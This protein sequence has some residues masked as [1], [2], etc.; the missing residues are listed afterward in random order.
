MRRL[1]TVSVAALALL[2]GATALG[3]D[4]EVSA[5]RLEA[6]VTLLADDALGGRE[7][8]TEGYN[9]AAGYVGGEFAA[10]GLDPAIGNHYFQTVP[11]RFFQADDPS[12]LSMTIIGRDGAQT[13]VPRDEIM[14]GTEAAVASASIEAPL[15]FVGSGFADDGLGWDDF[16]GV[17]VAGK[18]AVVLRNPP[19]IMG[20]QEYGYYRN[21]QAER[22]A[23]R[24]A[25]GM[26][27][28]VTPTYEKGIKFE[29]LKSDFEPAVN[30]AWLR[31]DGTPFAEVPD[32]FIRAFASEELGRRLMEGQPVSWEEAAAAE[33]DGKKRL[34][35]FELGF[36]ARLTAGN[37]LW[38]QNSYNVVGV[39]PGSDPAL[40]N[41][42][43][44]VTAHLDGVGTHVT[45]KKG[46]DE[47]VNAAMDNATGVAAI[48]EI[49][50]LLA[51]TPPRRTLV[52]AALTA[53]EKGL[54]GA[55]YLARN[56]V[57]AGTHKVVANINVD[58]PLSSWEFTDLVVYGVERT[59][60]EPVIRQSVASAGL[61]IVPDPQPEESYFTRSDHYRFVQQG[62]PS[63]YVNPGFGNGGDKAYKDF[64]GK[65]YHQPS[66]EVGNVDFRQLA[67]FT[68]VYRDI[69]VGV[70]NM[71]E[72]PLWRKGDFFAKFYGGTMED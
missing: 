10:I 18:I 27:V 61:V 28:L 63:V 8:G 54:W 5:E 3:H 37:R 24:G 51:P 60:M 62:I 52:F 41:E 16:S 6:D 38:Q 58:M 43:V 57:M 55:D 68:D 15:V 13:L 50:R 40:A 65:H 64:I 39:L 35:S 9:L 48:T 34:P 69:V 59:T 25:V 42:I 71:D 66:D 47:I 19:K 1:L 44:V 67:R 45:E 53:E 20:D 49:A 56:P 29:M 2:H 22:L 4:G 33:A 12:K 70:A 11:F 23:A 14:I 30:M 46:D 72:A 31:P 26:I 36:G 21:T 17:D 32:S 7:A